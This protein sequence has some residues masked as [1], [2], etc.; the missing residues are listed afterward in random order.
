MNH[1]VEVHGYLRSGNQVFKRHFCE[2][3][4]KGEPCSHPAIYKLGARMY[5]SKHKDHAKAITL[6]VNRKREGLNS[7]MEKQIRLNDSGRVAKEKHHAM[8]QKQK[9][10]NKDRRS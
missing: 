6:I 4:T 9:S 10:R 3:V 8:A 1:M 7:E 5:C 2:V